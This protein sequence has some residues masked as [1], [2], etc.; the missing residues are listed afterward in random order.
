MTKAEKF[1]QTLYRNTYFR[2]NLPDKNC[3]ILLKLMSYSAEDISKLNSL[4][5][6]LKHIIYNCTPDELD[7]IAREKVDIIPQAKGTLTDVQV[8]GVAFMIFSERCLIGDSTG[9]GKTVQ[10]AALCNYLKQKKAKTS[11]EPFRYLYLGEPKSVSELH[12]KMTTFTGIYAEL[13]NNATAQ[14]VDS[15]ISGQAERKTSLIATHSLLNNVNFSVFARNFPFD[16][17]II[18]EASMFINP[19]SQIYRNTALLMQKYRYR[20][21]LNATPINTSIKDLYNCLRLI[22]EQSMP[23]VTLFNNEYCKKELN[24]T[25]IQLKQNAQDMWKEA[26]KLRYKATLRQ[27]V[28]GAYENNHVYKYVI[29]FSLFQ[30]QHFRNTSK[31]AMLYDFPVR[32]VTAFPPY[33]PTLYNTPKVM[34]VLD[35]LKNK[36]QGEKCFIYCYFREAQEFLVSELEKAGYSVKTLLNTSAKESNAIIQDFRSRDDFQVLVSNTTKALDMQY[37]NHMILYSYPTESMVAVQVVGRMT[38]EIDIENK[39]LYLISMEKEDESTLEVLEKRF[40]IVKSSSNSEN[41]IFY[42]CAFLQPGDEGYMHKVY[43]STTIF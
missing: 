32:A 22:D 31:K 20:I 37:V 25:T 16:I 17:I 9:M 12:S 6:K 36:V 1:Y 8:Q 10:A 19:N 34:C 43:D 27:D 41:N 30:K 42:D 11:T 2:G 7:Y 3:E 24:R 40:N 4:S 35:I 18:D 13:L 23:P 28:Q 33:E 39:S 38:R 26:I 21:F 15:F 14:K 29:P 5:T